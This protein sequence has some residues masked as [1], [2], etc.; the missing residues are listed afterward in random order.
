MIPAFKE[1]IIFS[2]REMR[3]LCPRQSK[4]AYW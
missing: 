3:L 1:F 4:E 2:G